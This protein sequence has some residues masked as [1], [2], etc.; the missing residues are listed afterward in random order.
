MEFDIQT[1]DFPNTDALT[2]HTRRRLDFGLSRHAD[3]ITR[4]VV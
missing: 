4:V 3:R 1:L 2:Q